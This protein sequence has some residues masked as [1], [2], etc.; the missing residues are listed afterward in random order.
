VQVIFAVTDVARSAESYERAFGWLRNPLV[1]YASYVEFLPPDGG[2]VGVYERGAYAEEVGAEPVEPAD[3][4]VAPG[5]LYLRVE[6]VEATV[7]ALEEAGARPLSPLAERAWGE[8]AAWFADPDGNTIAVA[9]RIPTRDP[10]A[11]PH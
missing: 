2:A 5:Y 9:Q 4:R 6:D 8:Q 7:A 11:Q 3:A 10:A 1:D